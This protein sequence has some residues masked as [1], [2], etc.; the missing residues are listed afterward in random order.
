MLVQASSIEALLDVE[1][2][3]SKHCAQKGTEGKTG[4]APA[5]PSAV[6][7][8]RI[9]R[10]KSHLGW[11]WP[12]RPTSMACRH[13]FMK[14]AFCQRTLPWPESWTVALRHGQLA[15]CCRLDRHELPCSLLRIIAAEPVLVYLGPFAGSV[16][17]ANKLSKQ[18]HCPGVQYSES[19][20]LADSQ[21]R[22]SSCGKCDWFFFGA[23]IATLFTPIQSS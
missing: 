3:H 18:A 22:S 15:I 4:R 10:T 8:R 12:F 14:G 11:H 7:R 5:I 21:R 17:P 2:L 1:T 13:M 9:S 20:T 19:H 23:R 6:L 16:K